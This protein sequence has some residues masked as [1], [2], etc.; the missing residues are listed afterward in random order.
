MSDNASQ[1]NWYS[2]YSRQLLLDNFDEHSQQALSRSCVAVAGLGGLGHG[3]ATQLAASG[4]GTLILIDPDVVELSNL[5][6][7]TLYR[8]TDIGQSKAR[9]AARALMHINPAGQYH[10]QVAGVQ[11]ASTPHLLNADVVLDCTDNLASRRW[12]GTFC[13]HHGLPLI[14]GAAAGLEGLCIGF[15]PAPGSPCYG[16]LEALQ[17][18]APQNCLTQGI[19]GPVVNMVGQYQ[20]H[21]TLLALTGLAPVPWGELARFN[22]TGW[23]HLQLPVNPACTCCQH[24]ATAISTQESAYAAAD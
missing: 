13:Q 6:R 10:A 8:D 21:L 9:V 7:Q 4:V 16:C 15:S 1:Q 5:P 23:Q 12:L 22:G 20:A 14:T 2:R 3:A 19:L 11:D 18:F 17:A 24:H